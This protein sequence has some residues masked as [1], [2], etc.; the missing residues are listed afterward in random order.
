MGGLVPPPGM[1]APGGPGMGP[2]GPLDEMIGGPMMGPTE[3]IAA[4]IERTLQRGPI[5]MLRLM[6][7]TQE[8]EA[9]I[10]DWDS[11][12]LAG[13]E[14]DSIAEM[15]YSRAAEDASG[16]DR[17]GRYVVTAYR[18]GRDAY[19]ARHFFRIANEDQDSVF[20][21]EGPNQSGLVSQ[22]HRFA[23]AFG[24]MALGNVEAILR[25]MGRQMDRVVEQNEN[26]TGIHTQLILAQQQLLDRSA[27][28]DLDIRE[29]GLKLDRKDRNYR[30]AEGLV[31]QYL[32]HAAMALGLPAPRL[33]VPP[34]SGGEN[35]PSKDE[36]TW[37]FAPDEQKLLHRVTARFLAVLGDLDDHAFEAMLGCVAEGVRPDV[38]AIRQTLVQHA[39]DGAGGRASLSQDQQRQ[40]VTLRAVVIGLLMDLPDVQFALLVQ[41]VDEAARGD[42]VEMRRIIRDYMAKAGVQPKAAT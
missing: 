9:A 8:G 12:E 11:E 20:E 39:R 40:L 36:V 2:G 35:P 32:P 14:A 26:L 13:Q 24:R 38:R 41:Q 15:I 18:P 27:Q 22:A 37:T 6:Q 19:V 4:W 42:V 16:L 3:A 30:I 25:H 23:E 34:G 7:K 33:A 21:S 28:R 10:C 31:L 17:I 1:F 29:R 5:A